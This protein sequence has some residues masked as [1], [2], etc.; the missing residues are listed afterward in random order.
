VSAARHYSRSLELLP[1]DDTEERHLVLCNRA[2]VLLQQNK[3]SE[4]EAD[5][6]A[7]IAANAKWAKPW[8]RSGVARYKGGR[9]GEA[10]EDL[11]AALKLEPNSKSTLDEIK[12]VRGMQLEAVAAQRKA[13]AAK[14]RVQIEEVETDNEDDD[15][16]VINSPGSKNKP[17]PQGDK[18]FASPPTTGPGA[19]LPAPDPKKVEV[20]QGDAVRKLTVAVD[21]APPAKVCVLV[22]FT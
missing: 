13:A 16:I 12:I 7:A 8:Y 20:V 18:D 11:E 6:T 5:C 1:A 14:I 9:L 19:P 2:L 15:V 4:S 3:F 17:G 21:K 22:Y 10:L